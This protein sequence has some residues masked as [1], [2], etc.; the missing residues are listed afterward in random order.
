M[1][2]NMKKLK[3]IWKYLTS[4][5][6]R[7]WVDSCTTQDLISTNFNLITDAIKLQA[8]PL[9]IIKNDKIKK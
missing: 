5:S 6:Y 9:Y 1:Y 2:Q 8:H 4:P 3:H 7:F